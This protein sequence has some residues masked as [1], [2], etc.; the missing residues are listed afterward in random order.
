MLRAWILS[1]YFYI[2][3]MLG[4]EGRVM[5]DI[6]LNRPN[7]DLQDDYCQWSVVGFQ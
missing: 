6:S 3:E 2:S 5:G 4:T 7:Q 1:R